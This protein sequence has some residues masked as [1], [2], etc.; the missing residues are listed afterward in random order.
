M[1]P[2]LHILWFS[3]ELSNFNNM[4]DSLEQHWSSAPI[5]KAWKTYAPLQ[6]HNDIHMFNS[7]HCSNR[8]TISTQ[9]CI[10]KYI[11][12]FLFWLMTL[13]Q[14]WQH[15]SP[16]YNRGPLDGWPA[17]WIWH[18]WTALLMQLAKPCFSVDDIM[19]TA[20]WFLSL[21]VSEP[22]QTEERQ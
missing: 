5:T 2:K 11:W 3:M 9:P 1:T 22:A 7:T 14:S 12:T 8:T 20:K 6:K 17:F 10:A 13:I 16:Y 15:S 19:A 4:A 18:H 21:M